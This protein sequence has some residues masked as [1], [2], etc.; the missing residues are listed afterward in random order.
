MI[1]LKMKGIEYSDRDL[2]I[3]PETLNEFIGC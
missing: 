3:L 2:I 1:F